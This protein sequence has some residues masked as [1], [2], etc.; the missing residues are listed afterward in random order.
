MF[1][2]ASPIYL[3]IAHQLEDEILSGALA[4]DAQVMSTNQYATFYRINPA[5]AAK[6]LQQ[7][8]DDGILYKRRGLGMFVSPDAHEVLLARRRETFFDDVVAP[9]IAEARRIGIPVADIAAR[10]ERE[11]EAWPTT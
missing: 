10:L 5:T 11:G 4:P 2:D 1:D 7:L 8:V 3:Q 9:M 6:G